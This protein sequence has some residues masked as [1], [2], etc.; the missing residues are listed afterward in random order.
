[1]KP[2]ITFINAFGYNDKNPKNIK[3]RKINLK[4][5]NMKRA[6]RFKKICKL[7][8]KVVNFDAEF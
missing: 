2:D 7:I 6:R 5:K 4:Y 8:K 1:M 3:S